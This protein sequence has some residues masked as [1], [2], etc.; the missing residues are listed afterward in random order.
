MGLESSTTGI[1]IDLTVDISVAVAAR[2]S[3]RKAGDLD[4]RGGMLRDAHL[5]KPRIFSG[6]GL[7]KHP[8]TVWTDDASHLR[9][10]QNA[11]REPRRQIDPKEVV[12]STTAGR[13]AHLHGQDG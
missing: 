7:G 6:G 9:Y 3:S 2:T 13:L 1:P 4:S 10:R 8:T 5:H 11:H 12:W